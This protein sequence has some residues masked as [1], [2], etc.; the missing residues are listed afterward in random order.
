VFAFV[1]GTGLIRL[2]EPD[3]TWQVVGSQL[4]DRFIVHLAAD[5]ADERRLYAV[6]VDRNTQEQEILATSDGGATWSPLIAGKTG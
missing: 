3:F 6:T 2:T 5:P 1:V 4:G